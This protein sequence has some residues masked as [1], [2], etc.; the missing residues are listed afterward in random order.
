MNTDLFWAKSLLLAY[1]FDQAAVAAIF[2]YNASSDVPGF[3]YPWEDLEERLY[4]HAAARI[5]LVG[6][7]SL[8]NPES[9]ARSVR[10][11]PSDGHPP[12]VAVGARRVFNYRM[13]DGIFERYGVEPGA[14]DRAALNAEP[15]AES[16][17]NG[18]L[19]ELALADLPNLRVRET[20][21][22]LEPVTCLPWNK[23]NTAPFT[24][25]VLCC[26]YEFWEGQRYVDNALMPF[27]PYYRLCRTGA[28][29][30][31]PAFLNF[32]LKT[33]FLADR[34]TTAFD[35]EAGAN[36]RGNKLI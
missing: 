25:F 36:W 12:V 7:G 14:R 1:G 29:M 30:V 15:A 16:V 18:R 27:K 19:I 8:L 5:Y 11:T 21:Y 4:E 17:L 3:K 10:N 6:Y 33:C 28:E 23:P 13:P 26:K 24:A 22:D 34:S 35:L 2:E 32:Y 31:S 9:A 20:A